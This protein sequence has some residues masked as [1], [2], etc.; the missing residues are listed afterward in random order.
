MAAMVNNDKSKEPDL[1]GIK[2]VTMGVRGG[3]DNPLCM[4]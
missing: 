4:I 2:E 3:E 1:D